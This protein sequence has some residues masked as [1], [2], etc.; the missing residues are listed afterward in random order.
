MDPPFGDSAAA[1]GGDIRE[2]RAKPGARGL[3]CHDTIVR[4][5]P[6]TT[7]PIACGRGGDRGGGAGRPA[8]AGAAAQHR[9]RPLTG[10][11]VAGTRPPAGGGTNQELG[12]RY[13]AAGAVRMELRRAAERPAAPG[14][15]ARR[16]IYRRLACGTRYWLAIVA[17]R[18]GRRSRPG[19]RPRA[20][21]SVRPCPRSSR[22]RRL[23]RTPCSCRGRGQARPTTRSSTAS[24][25]H[26]PRLRGTRSR[27]FVRH[28]VH[29]RCCRA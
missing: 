11:P 23:V 8:V 12:R 25:A 9:R 16:H 28:V 29:A 20:R 5:E 14:D 2:E 10:G 1:L 21:C 24:R 7:R 27:R 18:R 17:R 13:V 15:E 26:R 19:G 3:G 22:L 4:L 6:V